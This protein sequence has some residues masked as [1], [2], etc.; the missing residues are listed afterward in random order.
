MLT[1]TL[2]ASLPARRAATALGAASQTCG[3]LQTPDG[4]AK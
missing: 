3:R 4:G 2:Q 1:I